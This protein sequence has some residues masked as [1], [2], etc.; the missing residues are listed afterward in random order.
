MTVGSQVPLPLSLGFSVSVLLTFCSAYLFIVGVCPE[1]RGMFSSVSGLYLLGPCCTLLSVTSRNVFRIANCPPNVCG[2]EWSSVKTTAVCTPLFYS[3]LRL[4]LIPI[5]LSW[6]L[7]YILTEKL[8]IHRLFKRALMKHAFGILLIVV[9]WG[10]V[11]YLA[12]MELHFPGFLSL[13]GPGLGLGMR[14]PVWHL[15]DGVKWSPCFN[16]RWCGVR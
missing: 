12:K 4:C 13:Y 9:P 8:R 10:F 14:R 2:G 3:D 16:G 11:S 1:H 7:G 5:T 6:L 15:E